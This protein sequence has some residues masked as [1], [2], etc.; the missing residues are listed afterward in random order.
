MNTP[1]TTNKPARN[2][3]LIDAEKKVR[4]AIKALQL[5][6]RSANGWDD[7]ST[8]NYFAQSLN[9]VLTCDHNEAGLAPYIA[10]TK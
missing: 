7:F 4:E 3:A 8:I 2:F 9:E 6:A 1:F 10:Q 5:A